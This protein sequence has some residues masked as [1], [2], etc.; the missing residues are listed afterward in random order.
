MLS[1]VIYASGIAQS[2]KDVRTEQKVQI[3]SN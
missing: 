3:K 2:N 1:P